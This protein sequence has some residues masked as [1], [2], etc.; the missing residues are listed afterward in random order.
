MSDSYTRKI[1]REQTIGNNPT[2]GRSTYQPS[3]LPKPIN[4]PSGTGG[5]PRANTN[6]D[7]Y[8]LQKRGFWGNVFDTLDD[9]LSSPIVKAGLAAATV[10]VG[11]Q[12]A[13]HLDES[14]LLKPDADDLG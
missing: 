12:L 13:K 9:A 14:G 6:R 5:G 7:D 4:V 8:S 1:Q 3:Y 10:A 2:L 11:Y